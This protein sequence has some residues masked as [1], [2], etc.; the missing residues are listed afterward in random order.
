MNDTTHVPSKRRGRT[1]HRPNSSSKPCAREGC[2]GL[3]NRSGYNYCSFICSAIDQEMDKAQRICQAIGSDGLTSELWTEVVALSDGL[4]RYMEL[5][6][7]LYR[8]ARSVGIT[9]EQWQAIKN[10]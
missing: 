9:D 10:G 4:T 2:R 1:R 5:D 3:I 7:R 8:E 6:R